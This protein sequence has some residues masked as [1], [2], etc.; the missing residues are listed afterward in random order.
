[1]NLESY[2][3]ERKIWDGCFKGSFNALNKRFNESITDKKVRATYYV[4]SRFK[5]NSKKFGNSNNESLYL[6]FD[7]NLSPDFVF[8]ELDFKTGKSVTIALEKSNQKDFGDTQLELSVQFIDERQRLFTNQ[9]F[10]YCKTVAGT[11]TNRLQAY[12]VAFDQAVAY[13]LTKIAD[14]GFQVNDRHVINNFA[15]YLY[16]E[17]KRRGKDEKFL[18]HVCPKVCI[19]KILTIYSVLNDD[20]FWKSPVTWASMN[21]N[22]YTDRGEE[23]IFYNSRLPIEQIE[24]LELAI[25]IRNSMSYRI[26]EDSYNKN[27]DFDYS[28]FKEKLIIHLKEKGIDIGQLT[29]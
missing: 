11:I 4:V 14:R 8:Q 7:S 19:N 25:R 24:G 3:H 15:G 17:N 29:Q 10:H 13:E 23:N 12:K 26:F 6:E 28:I 16:Y 5:N 27:R 9:S 2:G 20:V 22:P 21:N 18:S 1:M